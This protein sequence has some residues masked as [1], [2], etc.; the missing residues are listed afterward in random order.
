LLAGCFSPGAVAKSFC[1]RAAVLFAFVLHHALKWLI[2]FESSR[3]L[4]EDRH[5]GAL[6][7][8]LV[9]PV[10]IEEI[11]AGQQRALQ[12]LFRGPIWLAILANALLFCLTIFIN[13]DSLAPQEVVLLCELY[14]GG[15]IVMLVDFRALTWV[16]MWMA[17]LTRR[18]T[19]AIQATLLRVLLAP[20]LA[21]FVLVL[22]TVGGVG[23]SSGTAL[24]MSLFW[25][26]LAAVLSHAFAS[27]AKIGLL[28]AFRQIS[29]AP[30]L[31]QPNALFGQESLPVSAAHA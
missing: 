18:H 25:V 30:D 24:G 31:P 16:G 9:T 11:I 13:P 5:S 21:I 15:A 19:R 8:L 23:L 2:A 12:N 22:L 6:E 28:E 10:S 14:F 1:F 3:R 26:G 20:W 29:A 17:L 27:R 7:L 4:S